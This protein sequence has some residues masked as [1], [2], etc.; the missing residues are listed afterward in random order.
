MVR[1]SQSQNQ[2]ESINDA[3]ATV[4]VVNNQC[5]AAL[6]SPTDATIINPKR[7]LD[8]E[9]LRCMLIHKNQEIEHVILK[10]KLAL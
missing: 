8:L 1:P 10:S 4:N 6:F 5:L 2:P 3:A 7:I 9:S